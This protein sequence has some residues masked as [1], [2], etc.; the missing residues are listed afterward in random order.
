VSLS[1]G[2]FG[3]QSQAESDALI[4][5]LLCRD[6]V[7][8]L[9]LSE[10]KSECSLMCGYCAVLPVAG[11][12]TCVKKIKSVLVACKKMEYGYLAWRLDMLL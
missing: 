6:L 4:L 3:A 11:L 12:L 5:A 7:Q 1:G 8:S 2:K 10:L 9:L